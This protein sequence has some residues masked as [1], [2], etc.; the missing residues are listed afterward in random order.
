MLDLQRGPQ[1]EL[2]ATLPRD[3]EYTLA[4]GLPDGADGGEYYA[5]VIVLDDGQERP[6]AVEEADEAVEAPRETPTVTP[7]KGN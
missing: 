6:E 2:L 1:G 5:Q 3:G 7:R 4:I